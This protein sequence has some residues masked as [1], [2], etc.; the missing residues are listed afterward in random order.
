[1]KNTRTRDPVDADSGVPARTTLAT[2][3][4]SVPL[5]SGDAGRFAFGYLV[6]DRDPRAPGG[7]PGFD[8]RP[9]SGRR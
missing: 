5:D 2:T 9:P 8:T 6:F 1:M 4:I 7:A 3:P